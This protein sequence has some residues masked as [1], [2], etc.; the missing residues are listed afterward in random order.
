MFILLYSI[1]C[2]TRCF[3]VIFTAFYYDILSV[4]L[5]FS[6][7]FTVMFTVFYCDI[8]NV[9]LE[10]LRRFTVIFAAFYCDIHS[11]FYC[12]IHAAFTVIHTATT[13]CFTVIFTVPY[14]DIRSVLLWYSQ[15]WSVRRFKCYNVFDIECDI[16]LHGSFLSITLKSGSNDTSTVHSI[17][18]NYCD[19]I[20]F[21]C[22]VL[23]SQFRITLYFQFS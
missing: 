22:W 11:I 2:D 17:K 16:M 8:H 15:C 19:F 14:C 9:L 23:T 18:I 6:Q 21:D 1:Y 10:Y 5:W 12:C 4:L 7:F 3:T 13:Q 20:V